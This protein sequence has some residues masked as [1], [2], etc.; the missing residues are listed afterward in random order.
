MFNP[1]TKDNEKQMLQT[2]GVNSIQDLFKD[3]PQDLLNP[4]YNLPAALD[5]AALTRHI[6][7]LAAKNKPVDILNADLKDVVGSL[8][9]KKR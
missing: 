1:N 9:K 5:E 7:T 6:K 2:I 3:I 8:F 4:K